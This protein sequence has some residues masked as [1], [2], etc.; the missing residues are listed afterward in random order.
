[1]RPMNRNQA[2]ALYGCYQVFKDTTGFDICLLDGRGEKLL[3]TG[4]SFAETR[5][6]KRAV[7]LPGNEEG[8]L[9]LYSRDPSLY[10]PSA[11]QFAVLAVCQTESLL[12]AYG[13]GKMDRQGFMRDLL[14]GE[15]PLDEAMAR[16]R[17]FSIKEKAL[18]A[19]FL[20]E[21]GE[22]AHKV[23]LSAIKSFFR[24]GR[25]DVVVALDERRTVICQERALSKGRG[26]AAETD[27]DEVLAEARELVGLLNIEAMTP[28]Y[29]SVSLSGRGIENLPGAYQEAKAAMEVGRIF[30]AQE[31]VF[32]YDQLGIGRLICQIPEDVCRRFL[33][34]VFGD[35][36]VSS[37]D[38]EMQNTVRTLFQNNLN[39]AETSRQM[40]VHRNTLS[41]RLDKLKKEFGLD[42][43][44]FEDA[45]VFRL[46]MMISDL[47]RSR[48]A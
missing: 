46:A 45:M 25:E 8:T 9:L 30:F 40:Y 32:C 3:D 28:A 31:T 15:R 16:A 23:A 29:V 37:L 4:A 44:T 42:I 21:T 19:V 48:K 43:R 13:G 12:K 2:A 10:G 18:Y 38:E 34:D 27:M 41:Y 14:M 20:V 5:V 22:K 6:V 35:K 7:G 39:V 26:A 36:D 24:D 1:M 33:H 17:E 11:D 47:Q